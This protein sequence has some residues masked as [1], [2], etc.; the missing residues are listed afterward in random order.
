MKLFVDSISDTTIEVFTIGYT[1]KGESQVILLIDKTSK[2]PYLSFVIDCYTSKETNKTL[3]ILIEYGVDV[4]D[5]F[6]W[7]HTDEDHS[8]GIDKIIKEVCTKDTKFYLPELVHGNEKD[9]IDYNKDV[10]G[11]F[12][13]INSFNKGGN[14]SVSSISAGVGG[15]QTILT[16]SIIDKNT[17]ISFTLE[18]LGIAPISP[19]I[20]RRW[21][22][23]EAKKKNDLS[24]AT[25]FKV[26]EI[27]LLFSGD[28]ENQTIN[29]ISEFYFEAL[30]YIKTPHHTSRSSTQIIDK[31][32]KV[33]D[34]HKVTSSVST[35][36]KS[37]NLPDLDLIEDYKRISDRFSCTGCGEKGF[38][39]VQTTFFIVNKKFDEEL[40]G[41]AKYHY[42]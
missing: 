19:I 22:K 23:G 31:V 40:F 6:I 30:S 16:K 14:Y 12:D 36:Y 27:S 2:K 13:L 17:G 20:R 26:G 28:I 1:E 3:D 42:D 37:N 21:E 25:L 34:D 10:R 11:Y 24:I 5:Y 35:T 29:Q 38:G 4:L 7:T 41:D 33:N 8:M 39:Y 15:H 32:E 9:F 18:V